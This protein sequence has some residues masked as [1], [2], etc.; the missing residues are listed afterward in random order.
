MP[1]SKTTHASA[2]FNGLTRSVLLLT[3]VAACAPTESTDPANQGST[4]TQI[5][6]SP[7]PVSIAAGA[8][9]QFVATGT[10]GNGS[11]RNL[12]DSVTW[13]TSNPLVFIIS[14][15][16]GSRGLATGTGGGTAT[17][18]A[19]YG[20]SG[21]AS[22]TIVAVT[23]LTIS[24]SDGLNVQVGR[25]QQFTAEAR[26]SNTGGGVV[27]TDSVVWSSSNPSAVTI[28]NT[29]GTRGLAT[30]VGSDT[31]HV[32]ATFRG[33]S[34]TVAFAITCDVIAGGLHFDYVNGGGAVGRIRDAGNSVV[35]FDRNSAGGATG[36]A[37]RSAPKPGGAA[38]TLA[39]GIGRV[40]QFAVDATHLYWMESIEGHASVSYWVKRVALTGGSSQIL[41]TQSLA[42]GGSHRG[43]ALDAA[44]V[45]YA[46]GA[47][48]GA[49]IRIPK[50]GGSAVEY[51]RGKNFAPTEIMV[52]AGYVYGHDGPGGTR[53]RR[54][55]FTH[56]LDTLFS[57]AGQLTGL[58][59]DGNDLWIGDNGNSRLMWM[60][61][62]GGAATMLAPT[63]GWPYF[64]VDAGTAFFPMLGSP[65][66]EY[67]SNGVYRKA[68]S[69]GSSSLVV[70][71][72]SLGTGA[73]QNFHAI[74][75]TADATHI[76]MTDEGGS[77]T[78]QARV[79]KVRTP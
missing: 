57:G 79:L 40:S 62:S 41:V 5:Q 38:T 26:Y 18:S 52:D 24:P 54:L 25:T 3:A 64:V 13:S 28:S 17:V 1:T 8:T 30:R 42:L 60:P 74:G 19:T 6:V 36:G 23:S 71:N 76:F 14:D 46:D 48:G 51:G 50:A 63:A 67:P 70:Q 69:R 45:Y 59:L 2:R 49:I 37:F 55:S 39:S 78:G 68:K 66:T 4:L 77:T 33:Q 53:V 32:T 11:N 58:Q 47:S 43:L 72:C 31:A 15:D 29:A 61:K 21:T 9:Q 35:W 10:Y 16:A 73:G 65:G 12:T 75:L 34:D 20:I 44:Y 27:V 56:V 7:N 22:L